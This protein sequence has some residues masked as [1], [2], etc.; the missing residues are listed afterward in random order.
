MEGGCLDQSPFAESLRMAGAAGH[1]AWAREGIGGSNLYSLPC[2]TD[3]QY[4]THGRE[5]GKGG[6]EKAQYLVARGLRSTS[7]Q[8][9]LGC[10]LPLQATCS[11]LLGQIKFQSLKLLSGPRII[12]PLGK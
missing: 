10:R 9:E 7:C 12:D 2:E 1:K 11:P 8:S 3:A 4:L 5:I 6:V